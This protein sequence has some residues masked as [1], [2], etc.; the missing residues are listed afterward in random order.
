MDRVNKLSVKIYLKE[1][2][3]KNNSSHDC[4]NHFIED[5]TSPVHVIMYKVG[6]VE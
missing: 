4:T 6:P 5:S 2:T 3:D 1:I